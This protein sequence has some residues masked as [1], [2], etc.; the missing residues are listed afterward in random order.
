MDWSHGWSGRT[1][2]ISTVDGGVDVEDSSKTISAEV[3]IVPVARS[4][5]NAETWNLD[6]QL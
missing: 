1:V 6:Y 2:L 4:R 3:P 5:Q